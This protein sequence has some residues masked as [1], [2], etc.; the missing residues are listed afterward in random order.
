MITICLTTKK[1]WI[2]RNIHC[3]ILMLSHSRVWVVHNPPHQPL[4]RSAKF[5]SS[6]GSCHNLLRPA[7]SETSSLS[8]AG[9]WVSKNIFCIFSLSLSF[10]SLIKDQEIKIENLRPQ[11]SYIFRVRAKNE[12]GAGAP[13]DYA[14]ETEQIRKLRLGCGSFAVF[15]PS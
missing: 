15:V 9:S 7:M 3:R 10:A 12:V 8:L 4:P 2:Y 5:S 11:T 14:H 1:I 13:K 6:S